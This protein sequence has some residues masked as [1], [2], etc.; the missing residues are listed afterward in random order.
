ME[1]RDASGEE[2]KVTKGGPD[3]QEVYVEGLRAL[4]SA[5][6]PFLV[7]GGYALFDYLGRW[8]STKD[9]DVFLHPEEVTPALSALE[10]TG[11]TVEITDPAWLAKA[12]RS[13]ALIDVIFCS[14][15]GLFPVDERWFQNARLTSVLGV[16]VQIV[17]PEEMIVSKAFVAARDRFD[18]ADISWLIRAT[19]RTLDWQRIE[20]MM[21]GHWQVLLWQMIHFLYVFPS[22]RHLLPPELMA[23]LMARLGRELVSLDPSERTCRG[24]ML[25]P[26]LYLAEIASRGQDPRPRRELVR[27]DTLDL[28][29]GVS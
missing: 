15:N 19:G 3:V 2:G 29:I 8:R 7:G 4:L 12:R 25:D 5:K 22:E 1:T 14:Y 28:G 11:F 10:Q 6:I 24:P 13:G 26:V 23:R 9:M 18:G 21:A 27:I 17:G 16:P 20:R